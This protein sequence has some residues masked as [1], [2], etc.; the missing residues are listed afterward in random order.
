MRH[1][2]RFYLHCEPSYSGLVSVKRKQSYCKWQIQD[3]FFPRYCYNWIISQPCKQSIVKNYNSLQ[4]SPDFTW[5]ICCSI[6]SA[7]LP[8]FICLR[9]ISPW[10]STDATFVSPTERLVSNSYV[11]KNL[12]SSQFIHLQSVIVEWLFITSLPQLVVWM[13]NLSI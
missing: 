1:Q 12:V 10:P 4:F 8:C 9:T 3:H 5:I 13:G 2:P 7:P 6:M 11:K